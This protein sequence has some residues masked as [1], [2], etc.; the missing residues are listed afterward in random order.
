MKHNGAGA[1]MCP[2]CFRLH[3]T[4]IGWGIGQ[5]YLRQNNRWLLVGG[6]CNYEEDERED[7]M[8]EETILLLMD[9]LFPFAQ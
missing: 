6:F 5:L 1:C 3:G 8:D 4:G 2:K 7:E 9:S